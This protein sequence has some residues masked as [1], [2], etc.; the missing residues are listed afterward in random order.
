MTFDN[1]S[2]MS[3]IARKK[4]YI[5]QRRR[6]GDSAIIIMVL[7]VAVFPETKRR[8]K[9]KGGTERWQLPEEGT[10]Y[11]AQGGH[12]CFVSW[13]TA[14]L[15]GAVSNSDGNFTEELN[16]AWSEWKAGSSNE[17]VARMKKSLWLTR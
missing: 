13:L 3:P 11:F 17:D 2:H 10:I 4:I 7:D 9:R 1:Q 14:S 12:Q 16:L 8:I 5:L 6:T 15:G